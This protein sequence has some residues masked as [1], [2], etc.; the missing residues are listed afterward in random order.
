MKLRN[1]DHFVEL[2]EDIPGFGFKALVDALYNYESTAWL[3]RFVEYLVDEGWLEDEDDEEDDEPDANDDCDAEPVDLSTL[4]DSEVEV[5]YEEASGYVVLYD[6]L[7]EV[8]SAQSVFEC[9][10]NTRESRLGDRICDYTRDY[11]EAWLL[12]H[13]PGAYTR[14]KS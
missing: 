1:K 8:E 14:S 9:A 6:Y 3:E 11:A 10:G 5:E 13:R 12:E 4:T 7:S 2:V